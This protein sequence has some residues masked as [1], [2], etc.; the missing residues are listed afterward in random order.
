LPVSLSP[1]EFIS[2]AEETGI[3]LPQDLVDAVRTTVGL[4]ED[5]RSLTA[6]RDELREEVKRLK[7]E[8]A[9]N[10]PLLTRER[11]T[12]QKIILGM[13]I[14]GYGYNPAAG[15]SNAPKEIADDLANLQIHV[16]DDTV[17]H[18]LKDAF[19]TIGLEP[20]VIETLK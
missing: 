17:R 8:A 13:A 2:W 4:L 1:A 12:Y 6:E 3:A 15:R 19:D 11:E 7:E 9:R 14:K 16:S 18:K 20:E 5:R 10:K